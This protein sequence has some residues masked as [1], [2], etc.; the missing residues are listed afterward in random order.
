LLVG[1]GSISKQALVLGK[2]LALRADS[3]ATASVC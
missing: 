3:V 1:Q 2:V